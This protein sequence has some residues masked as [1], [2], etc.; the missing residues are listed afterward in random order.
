[1]ST[2]NNLSLGL[3]LTYEFQFS[4][5]NFFKKSTINIDIDH[6]NYDYDDFRNVLV[7]P[8]AE[9]APVGAEPLYQFSANITRF[10]VSIF[11]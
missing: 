1:M 4:A 5:A 8:A 6:V 2:F 7:D 10:Y 9:V 3:S 11:Y